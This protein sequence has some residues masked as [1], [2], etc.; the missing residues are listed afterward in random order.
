MG[1]QS[2][3]AEAVEAGGV[4]LQR[5]QVGR[6]GALERAGSRIKCVQQAASC[7]AQIRAGIATGQHACR[8]SG[9]RCWHAAQCAHCRQEQQGGGGAAPHATCSRGAAAAQAI[10]NGRQLPLAAQQG[11]GLACKQRF[12]H[13]WGGQAAGPPAI[14]LTARLLACN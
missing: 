12:G 2:L 13:G 14:S 10:R 11:D 1:A 7:H 8:A 4:D 3:D 6:G 5:L 9:C